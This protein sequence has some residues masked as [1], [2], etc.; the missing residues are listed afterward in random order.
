MKKTFLFILLPV[1]IAGCAHTNELARYDL[2][3]KLALYEVLI[4]PDAKRIDI[5]SSDNESQKNKE[6]SL[7]ETIVSVGAGILSASSEEKLRNAVDTKL[8]A[9]EIAEGMK[10]TLRTYLNVN[11][12]KNI[13]DDPEFIVETILEDCALAVGKQGVNVKVKAT[14]RILERKSGTLAWEN[15]EIYFVPIKSSNYKDK[16]ASYTNTVSDA[17][18]AIKLAS[19]SEREINSI[20]TGA[21]YEVGQKMIETL[22]ED[23]SEVKTKK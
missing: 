5:V 20:V 3:N 9:D 2:N 6:K 7:L 23:I 11:D 16:N 4:K 12:T 13:S 15:S 18:N 22:R 19:L 1:L 10:K 8:L 14:G 17:L 21:A